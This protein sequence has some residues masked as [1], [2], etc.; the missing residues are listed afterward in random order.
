MEEGLGGVA[1]RGEAGALQKSG[2]NHKAP[3]LTASTA[4]SALLSSAPPATASAALES[5]LP[6][7]VISSTRYT[8]DQ[9]EGIYYYYNISFPTTEPTFAYI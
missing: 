4:A 9:T 2:L 7:L 5:R 8:Y 3:L 1:A 6:L